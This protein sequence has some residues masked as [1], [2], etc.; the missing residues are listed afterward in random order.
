M[1]DSADP[2]EGWTYKD[3]LATYSGPASSDIYGKL[4]YYIKDILRSFHRR[5]STLDCNIQLFNIDARELPNY[6]QKDSFARVDV[7]IKF[8]HWLLAMAFQ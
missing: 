5:L 4:Y 3:V 1:P 6:L 2:L 7:R 8:L